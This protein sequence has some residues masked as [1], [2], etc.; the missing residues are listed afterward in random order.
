MVKWHK[1][2]AGKLAIFQSQRAENQFVFQGYGNS[3]R[4]CG[5]LGLKILIN[6]KLS[7]FFSCLVGIKI[8]TE[9]DGHKKG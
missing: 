1:M 8:K 4:M 2:Q 5:Y 7:I 3:T 6:V 9:E